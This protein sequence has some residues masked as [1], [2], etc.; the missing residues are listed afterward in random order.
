MR[1]L[2]KI[3]LNRTLAIV[4]GFIVSILKFFS[5]KTGGDD[6]NDTD[7]IPP[8]PKPPLRRRGRPRKNK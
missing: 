6:T 4:F 8:L 3:A 5:L 7:I 2:D 1:L